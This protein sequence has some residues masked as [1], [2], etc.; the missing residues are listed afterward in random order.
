[1][2]VA[3]DATGTMTDAGNSTI[4]VTNTSHTVG[5][6]LSNSALLSIVIIWSAT[7]AWPNTDTIT[8][9]WDSVGLTLIGRKSDTLNNATVELWGLIAPNA[10]NKT[11]SYTYTGSSPTASEIG[12]LSLSF[13]GVNQSSVAAAF[14]NFASAAATS[15]SPSVTVTSPT[16]NIG[17]AAFA[18]TGTGDITPFTTPVGFTQ[19][20]HQNAHQI[21]SIGARAAG[22]GSLV[23]AATAASSE[24]WAGAGVNIVAASAASPC[25]GLGLLGV[26]CGISL[27]GLRMPLLI[28][29]AACRVG[30]HIRRNATLSRRQFLGAR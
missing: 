6:A 3:I 14:T 2:A 22:A 23:F 26:G 7:S 24:A 25:G 29:G 30:Q 12:I 20:Y 19:I 16:G 18:T 9:T 21:N 10:G 11:L 1:M 17:V 27:A 4:P 5:A 8:H 28:G 15:T 13:S